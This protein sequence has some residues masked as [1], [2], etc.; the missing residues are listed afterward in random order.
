MTLRPV[1]PA[2]AAM[3]RSLAP[4][5]HPASFTAAVSATVVA[6]RYHPDTLAP[7]FAMC[8]QVAEVDNGYGVDNEAQGQPIVVCRGLRTSWEDV[9]QKLRQLD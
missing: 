3:I 6:V 9:W 1:A 8:R 2:V 7:F 4:R 5:G